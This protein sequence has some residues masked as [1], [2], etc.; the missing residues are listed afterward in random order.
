MEHSGQI[1]QPEETPYLRLLHQKQKETVKI[2][3]ADKSVNKPVESPGLSYSYLQVLHQ[4][5]ANARK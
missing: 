5:Q 3:K 4:K 2:T 1:V